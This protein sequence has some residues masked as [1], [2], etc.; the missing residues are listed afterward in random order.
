MSQKRAVSTGKH[1]VKNI[2][3]EIGLCLWVFF[4]FFL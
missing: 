1:G 2:Q 3:S 4:F